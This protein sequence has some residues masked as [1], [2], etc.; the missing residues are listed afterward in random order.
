MKRLKK[1]ETQDPSEKALHSRLSLKEREEH[2][3]G[4][5][6]GHGYVRG[7]DRGQGRGDRGGYNQPNHEDMVKNPQL[8]RGKKCRKGKQLSKVQ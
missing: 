4:G 7:Q 5:G 2:D 1:R 8:S 6:Q 3:Q